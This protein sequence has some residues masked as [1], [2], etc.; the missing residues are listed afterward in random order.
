MCVGVILVGVLYGTASGVQPYRT[1]LPKVLYITICWFYRVHLRVCDI[2]F[3]EA[4]RTT[5]YFCGQ[6]LLSITTLLVVHRFLLL[7]GVGR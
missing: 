2:F 5:T 6:Q 4:T 3:F 1:Y 7:V